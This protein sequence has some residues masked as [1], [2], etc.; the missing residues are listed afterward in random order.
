MSSISTEK[1]AQRATLKV[2]NVKGRIQSEITE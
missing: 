2:S 1:P